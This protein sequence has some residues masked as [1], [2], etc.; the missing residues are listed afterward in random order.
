MNRTNL[1]IGSI[2]LA[3]LLGVGGFCGW[4]LHKTLHPCPTITTDTISIPDTNWYHLKDSLIASNKQLKKSLAYWKA[5]RD[6]ITLPGDSIP[7]P[8]EVDTS[9]I[10]KDYFAAYKYG[11]S[12]EDSNIIVKDTIHVTQNIPYWHDLTYKFKKPFTTIINNV[13]NSI[14]YNKYIQFGLSMPVYSYSDSTKVNLQN[15]T[16]EATYVFPKGYIGAGWQPNT[17]SV[18]ARAGVTLFKFKQKK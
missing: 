5:H 4:S 14:T 3:V 15:L 9:A 12:K 1:I 2:I 7:Y 6:T 11:W 17:Q 18:M 10:L 13:D 16:L 8:V